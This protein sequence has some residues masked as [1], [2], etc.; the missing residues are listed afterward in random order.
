MTAIRFVILVVGM[1]L[2]TVLVQWW[3]IPVI[4]CVYGVVARDTAR[5]ALV[6]MAAA[7]VAWGGY[8]A[9]LAFGGAPIG[10]F[11]ADLAS[12]MQLP[13][14]VPLLAT[15]FFPSAMAGPAAY[16]GA[17]LTAGPDRVPGRR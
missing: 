12:A 5:P 9:I 16:L 11:G 14:L 1:A 13:S 15:L 10:R 3:V 6:A 8:L 7:A 17:H 4:A 2:G